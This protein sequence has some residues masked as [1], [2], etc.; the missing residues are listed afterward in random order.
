MR[1]ITMRLEAEIH[2]YTLSITGVASLGCTS[3]DRPSV[4]GAF[5]HQGHR[6]SPRCL[7]AF[8]SELS[9]S[10]LVALA[11]LQV[12]YDESYTIEV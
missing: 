12:R 4:P 7:G 8:R 3:Y 6:I 5:I 10:Q 2:S 9:E 11:R 1:L